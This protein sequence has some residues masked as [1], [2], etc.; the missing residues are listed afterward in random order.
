MI[1]R[2]HKITVTRRG[3]PDTPEYFAREGFVMLSHTIGTKCWTTAYQ[4]NYY[5]EH[6]HE[7][8]ERHAKE[9]GIA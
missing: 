5:D 2:G 8:Y 7:C 1:Y 3:Y 6:E 9:T 4:K